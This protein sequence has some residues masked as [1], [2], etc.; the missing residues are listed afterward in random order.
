MHKHF[1]LAALEQAWLGR[2]SC[3]PNPS[4]GAVAVH[5][6]EIIAKSWHRGAGTAHAEQLVLEQIPPGLKNLTLYVTLEPCNHW[7]K[8]PPCVTGIIQYGVSKVVYGFTDPNPLVA[9]NNTP[10]LLKDKNIEVVHYPLPELSNFYQSYCFWLQTK[11][12]WVTAKIAQSLDGKIGRNDSRVYL[13]NEGCA[14]FTH[15]NRLTTDVI[16][17]TAKT[18]KADD[19]LLNARVN[20]KE[21]NKIL[22]I[23][24]SRLTLPENAK[25]FSTAARCHIYHDEKYQVERLKPNCI[26]HPVPAKHG[27]LDLSFIINHLGELG[28]HDVWVEAGGQLF[29]ALH[30]AKLVQRTYLYISPQVLGNQAVSAFNEETIFKNKL[31]ISWQIKTDNVIACIDLQ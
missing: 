13:S 30:Q 15:Q 2:G 8:T 11:K 1:M 25:V 12:P 10:Q 18:I 17:T 16:L 19:P 22:A 29:S 24:D 5:E 14:G 21:Q 26:Y 6:G 23:L 27:L 20:G 9:A 7:G 31:N 28:Y 3:A 4:V